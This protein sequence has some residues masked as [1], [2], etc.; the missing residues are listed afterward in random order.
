MKFQGP[1]RWVRLQSD[2]KLRPFLPG[3]TEV[4]PT[5]KANADSCGSLALSRVVENKVDFPEGRGAIASRDSGALAEH[6]Y[7][8]RSLPEGLTN[9]LPTQRMEECMATAGIED[10][11]TGGEDRREIED[12]LPG[13]LRKIRRWC[14]P[15]RWSVPDWSAEV[16][17]EMT[18]AAL[19]A[20][21]DFDPT[22]GVPR[23]VFLRQRVMHL[24]YS[25]YRR[26]LG[27][28][29]RPGRQGAA[30]LGRAIRGE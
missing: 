10:G 18:F 29:H 1:N 7:S 8:G 2:R 11:S 19:Q 23:E 24:A 3:P 27:L 22:R 12:I 4:G 26:E 25:H 14:V 17:A 13:C 20:A 15:P 5:H 6:E 30:R 16:A 21:R 28:R 9:S